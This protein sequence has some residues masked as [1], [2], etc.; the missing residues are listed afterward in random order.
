LTRSRGEADVSI[1][2]GEGGEGRLCPK[3]LAEVEKEGTKPVF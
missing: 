1:W 3:E 2:L